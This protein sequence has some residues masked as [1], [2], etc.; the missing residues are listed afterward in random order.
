[1]AWTQWHYLWTG[2]Y[3]NFIEICHEG[4][5]SIVLLRIVC[6]FCSGVLDVGHYHSLALIAETVESR[7]R[8]PFRYKVWNIHIVSS[9]LIHFPQKTLLCSIPKI[10]WNMYLVCM[11]FFLFVH[12]CIYACMLLS[13]INLRNES[14][15]NELSVMSASQLEY[16]FIWVT[17]IGLMTR[18]G[19]GQSGSH[20]RCVS[21][22][23]CLDLLLGPQSFLFSG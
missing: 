4:M 22:S 8:K 12:A 11:C 7:D 2:T 1:V 16:P 15:L 9:V 20:K 21:F 6:Q 13:S 10:K 17:T 23:K 3:G 5:E 18:L 14:D 19:V